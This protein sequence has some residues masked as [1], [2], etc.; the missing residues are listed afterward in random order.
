MFGTEGTRNLVIYKELQKIL[1]ADQEKIVTNPLI[2]YVENWT[3]I[4]GQAYTFVNT[5]SFDFPDKNDDLITKEMK[6]LNDKL[7]ASSDLL[8]WVINAGVDFSDHN[9]SLQSYLEKKQKAYVIIFDNFDQLTRSEEEYLNDYYLQ[10]LLKGK[11]RF[12]FLPPRG[13]LIGQRLLK[14]LATEFAF[15]K[16]ALVQSSGLEQITTKIAPTKLTIF[17]PPN[18]GK[19]TLL[20]SLV[21]EERSV[22]SAIAGT[23]KEDVSTRWARGDID[24]QLKDTEGIIGKK[25]NDR[26]VLKDCNIAWVIIDASLPITK[27][28]LQIVNLASKCEKAV[29]IILNKIDLIDKYQLAEVE[30]EIRTR[31]KSFSFVPIISISA[32]EK[33]NFTSLLTVLDSAIEQ[34]KLSF[35]KS[36]IGNHFD[37]LIEKNPPS[38]IKGKRL[39]IYYAIHEVGFIHKFV[40]FVNSPALVHFSYERYIANYLR[41]NFKINYLPIKLFFKKS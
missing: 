6:S 7:I 12:Y 18:S 23:T 34:S 41:K 9:F 15:S 37:L 36:M 5:Y 24:F 11:V 31:L 26:E 32:I 28:T 39:K 13:R 35:S 38:N 4:N 27:Q 2:N 30:E 8:L 20:N 1:L 25:R 19:S 40:I 14:L 33:K 10:K 17:G 16:L 3:T 21:Q 29:L 22:V